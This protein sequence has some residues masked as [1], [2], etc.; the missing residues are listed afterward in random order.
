MMVK[1]KAQLW[2]KVG[3]IGFV[4]LLAGLFLVLNRFPPQ[5]VLIKVGQTAPRV[6]SEVKRSI[7]FGLEPNIPAQTAQ[8][9]QVPATLTSPKLERATGPLHVSTTNPRYFMDSSGKLVYLTGSHTWSNL[10]DNGG[11]NPPPVFDYNAYL[12]FLVQNNHNFFRLWT[13]EQSRWTVETGDDQYWFSPLPYSRTGPGNALD[14]QPR[15]DLS[16]FNQ[17]Y[18]DRMRE[19]ITAAGNRGI[20]VSIM[21]FDGWSIEKAKGQ[22]GQNNPWRGHPFNKNN[23][24][25]QIDGDPNHN[26]SGEETQTLSVPEIT[27]LQEAYIRKVIDS[28]NDLDNVLYEISNESHNN[29]EA[30]QVHLIEYIKTYEA[31]KPKQ[32]PVGMTSPWPGGYNP[33][34]YASPADWISP[35]NGDGISYTDPPAADGSKVVLADTDHLC[36]ICG[37]RKWVWKT[38]T[39]GQN[40]IFMDGY[41][42]AGFGV[43]GEGFN[44]ND[45]NWV[46]LR[47]N[48]GYTRVYA[49]RMNLASMRPLPDLASTGYCL[50]NPATQ[51][52]EYLVYL[53]TGGQVI[54]D[55]SGT[56]GELG[57]EWFN[58]SNGQTVA[59]GKTSGGGNRSFAPPFS[60]DAVLYL[61][62]NREEKT[63]SYSFLPLVSRE[64]AITPV[65]TPTALPTP[66]LP[67][68]ADFVETF[69]GAPDTPEPWSAE[70]WDIQVHSRDRE[71]W[72]T[73]DPMQAAHGLNCEP[74]PAVHPIS[75]YEQAVFRCHDHV[76]TALNAGG[77]GVIYLTPNRLVDFSNG[78]AVIRFDMSTLRTSNR[79][80]V[81]FWITPYED[82]LALPLDSEVDLA[83]TPKNTVHIVM[84]FGDRGVFKG[85]VYRNYQVTPLEIG[86]GLGYEQALTPSAQIRSMFELRIARTH[87]KFGLPEKG[88]WW[89]DTEI[90]DLGWTA[91][92]FQLGHHSYNPRKECQ[93]SNLSC[94][95]NTWHW[96]N[97]RISPAVPFT[98][99]KGDRRFVSAEDAP[100][101][102]VVNFAAP[103]PANAFL[104]FSGVGT[105]QVSLNGGPFQ[106]A[107]KAQS[108]ELPGIGTYHPEHFSSYWMP[109]PSGTQSVQLRFNGDDWYTTSFPMLAKDFA[110]WSLSGK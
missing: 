33:D 80:W 50:A 65:M 1:Q 43:G 34:L 58:P 3:I 52:G 4:L 36:G 71:T 17:E 2:N 19:R 54:V 11:S 64:A 49:N 13:W 56:S 40:P 38:F 27:A 31:G 108:S 99:I 7:K 61:Y 106:A 109:V 92:I 28:V 57:V 79:D 78:E 84:D 46:N 5:K 83:G 21:L 75:E 39:R 94:E 90:P 95:P 82:N 12:D 15:F 24:I 86:A 51:G 37:D 44:F 48:L 93:N 67:P 60:G 30:W 8:V 100:A 101:D 68:G 63:S 102:Q 16:K 105:I 103:A 20:Y 66:I 87:I 32:H 42:G 73:L 98:M 23:N 72:Y 25:N 96:D 91:G 9:E 89:I 76:M 97:I 22:F 14:G 81:D 55:L 69:D 29:S 70:G 74:P 41:D 47:R 26:D 59:G 104:R 18:F 85:Y 53:P 10:Q 62:P 6:V 110:I 88:L 45:P 107:V 35:N 77:Y